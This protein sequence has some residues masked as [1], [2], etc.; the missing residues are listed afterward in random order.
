ME[1]EEA[2][3][4]LSLLVLFSL[5][6]PVLAGPLYTGPLGDE[7]TKFHKTTVTA[8]ISLNSSLVIRTDKLI[9]ESSIITNG[10]RLDIE[11]REIEVRNGSR[12]IAFDS[13][14]EGIG[15][16]PAAPINNGKTGNYPGGDGGTGPDGESGFNGLEGRVDPAHISVKSLLVSGSLNIN[17]DGQKGGQGGKGGPGGKGGKGG[18]GKN[19]WA[20]IGWTCDGKGDPGT[21]GGNG[22]AGGLG[23]KGGKGGKGGAN[24][25]LALLLPEGG[26]TYSSEAGKGGAGGEPGDIGPSGDIGIGGRGGHDSYDKLYS[27]SHSTNAGANGRQL[28]RRESEQQRNGRRGEDGENF[29]SKLNEV[30]AQSPLKLHEQKQLVLGDAFSFHYA[31]LFRTLLQDS[32]RVIAQQELTRTKLEGTNIEVAAVLRGANQQILEQLLV[33]WSRH[34]IDQIEGVSEFSSYKTSAQHLLKI[35]TSLK[36]LEIDPGVVNKEI[37]SLIMSADK[38]VK[39]KLRSLSLQCLKFNEILLENSTALE[40]GAIQTP[41]CTQEAI[42]ELMKSPRKPVVVNVK[43]EKGIFGELENSASIK[44]EESEVNQ[45]RRV[46][47]IS[48]E[49]IILYNR[50]YTEKD[51]ERARPIAGDGTQLAEIVSYQIPVESKVDLTTLTELIKGLGVGA[52]VK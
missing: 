15:S 20:K 1:K 18:D 31:R 29:Q 40:F 7:W 3:E 33:A 2:M 50:T 23:G 49:V 52:R 38:L 36:T 17:A 9:I 14:Q 41:V 34:F 32:L 45:E 24:V 30:L 28:V 10:H 43:V 39:T 48:N 26:L 51:F 8:P 47:Q 35:L 19:G 4:R 22:G 5:S 11:A 37:N 27:C 16:I 44:V 12:I 21:P 42:A 13:P 46:A 6:T 25:G